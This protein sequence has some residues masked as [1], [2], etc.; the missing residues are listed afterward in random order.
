MSIPR[1][2]L[3][4]LIIKASRTTPKIHKLLAPNSNLS[5]S[6]HL[7][8]HKLGSENLPTTYNIRIRLSQKN[9]S[10]SSRIE[11]PRN[12]RLPST[13]TSTCE[14]LYIYFNLG[15]TFSRKYNKYPQIL[16]QWLEDHACETWTI[17]DYFH[18]MLKVSPDK[19][20]ILLIQPLEMKA[21]LEAFSP[22]PVF[23][24]E[25]NNQ[26]NFL[27][28]FRILFLAQVGENDSSVL[29]S[30]STSPSVPLFPSAFC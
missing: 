22:D 18:I 16:G 5:C 24:I 26:T 1:F 25:S 20:R 3:L 13:L 11:P 8:F 15:I 28:N 9:K 29:C 17:K 4:F 27:P 2:F 14:I 21:K 30:Q 7:I 10:R 23:N 6:H 12:C 19:F